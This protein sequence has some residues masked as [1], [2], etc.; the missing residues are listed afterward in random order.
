MFGP[1]LRGLIVVALPET[2]TINWTID[3]VMLE[4]Q[5]G[6]W[7]TLTKTLLPHMQLPIQQIQVHMK[8]S[9]VKPTSV[10]LF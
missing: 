2:D 4:F 6:H 9:V 10:D 5:L 8:A 3:G 1:H 7:E